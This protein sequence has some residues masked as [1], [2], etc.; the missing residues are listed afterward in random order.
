MGGKPSPATQTTTTNTSG[1]AST[2]PSAM[3]QPYFPGLY[4]TGQNALTSNQQLP[5]PQ[6]FVAGEDPLQAQA[7]S[8]A[9]AAAPTLGASGGALSDM[10][11]KIASGYFLDPTNDP[12]FAGA[13]N[14]ALTPILQNVQET[15]LP[16]VINSS[17]RGGGVGGGPTAYG[18]ANA[19]SAQDIMEQQVLRNFG[20]TAANTTASMANASRMAGMNLIPQAPGIAQGANAQILAPSTELGTLGSQQQQFSQ[21]A[22]N[23]LLQQYQ[24]QLQAPWQGISNMTNLLTAGGYGTST[25]NQTGTSV[26]Q[27]QPPTPSMATQ[28]LQGLTGGASTL[29]S[30]FGSGPNGSPSALS[31]IWSGLGSGLGNIAGGIG[32]MMGPVS[33]GAGGIAALPLLL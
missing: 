24:T 11:Q 3:A 19:G 5:V 7:I 22:I 29:N 23:N 1:T 16:Q 31:N 25:S 21:N 20:Q 4:Q 8:Q 30:L 9:T 17:I 13:V 15:L 33:G 6:Q 27:Y 28:I 12:T 14:S 32:A 26:G 2:G 10:A 18:G